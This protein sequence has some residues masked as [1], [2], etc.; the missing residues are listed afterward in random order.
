M[1]KGQPIS[2]RYF[3]LTPD[4]AAADKLIFDGSNGMKSRQRSLAVT[5]L[6][7]LVCGCATA[8]SAGR[9]VVAFAEDYL[10]DDRYRIRV[11][12]RHGTGEAW[13]A[14]QA[15]RHAA[16][17]ATQ[18]GA[19]GFTIEDR[20]FLD[21]VYTGDDGAGR[22][23]VTYQPGYDA[24]RSYWRYYR[25]GVGLDKMKREPIWVFSEKDKKRYRRVELDLVVRLMRVAS[26]GMIEVHLCLQRRHPYCS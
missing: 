24:W 22:V 23:R 3:T 19:V 10:G 8:G 16:Q 4:G 14:P 6:S 11:I 20:R 9:G 15:A 12:A 21:H 26:P 25:Y 18:N 7:T 1:L 17:L 13:L 5:L 2:F